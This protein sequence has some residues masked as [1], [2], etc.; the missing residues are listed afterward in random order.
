[1]KCINRHSSINLRWECTCSTSAS[2]LGASCL[3]PFEDTSMAQVF[4]YG[5]LSSCT[6]SIQLLRFQ[7]GF[8]SIFVD[9]MRSVILRSLQDVSFG[10]SRIFC[11]PCRQSPIRIPRATPLLYEAVMML[12]AIRKAT[13]LHKSLGVRG[14]KLVRTIIFDQALYFVSYVCIIFYAL[15]LLRG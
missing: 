2:P 10:A 7:L 3:D 6:H 14:I 12:L 11:Y 1:M 5:S 13:Q 8:C 15:N 4:D 9:S